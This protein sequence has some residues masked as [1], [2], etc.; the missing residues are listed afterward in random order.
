[1][2]PPPPSASA[3]SR[4]EVLLED[5]ELTLHQELVVD[6]VHDRP[7][8]HPLHRVLVSASVVP[9][10][11]IRTAAD[12]PHDRTAAPPPRLRAA[13]CLL[14]EAASHSAAP[15]ARIHREHSNVPPGG[16]AV[17]S[18]GKL[19]LYAADDLARVVVHGHDQ[20]RRAVP[21]AALE[22]LGN[23]PDHL[24]PRARP[25]HDANFV[26]PIARFPVGTVHELHHTGH[27]RVLRPALTEGDALHLP[28]G[29]DFLQ[30]AK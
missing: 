14:E 21:T 13:L 18:I 15:E 12:D 7:G 28:R 24:R 10:Q 27:L 5:V 4:H 23:A 6:R 11:D 3:S 30:R 19:C 9:L 22:G 26:G 1:M 17:L 2:P 16:R 29:G 20:A 25:L 8:L